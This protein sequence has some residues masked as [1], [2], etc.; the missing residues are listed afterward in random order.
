M[1]DT[2]RV[3][4]KICGMRQR[5]NI[6][7]VASLHPDYMGFIFYKGSK[8]FVGNDFG[9]PTLFP[10]SIKRIGVFVNAQRKKY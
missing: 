10:A 8:R 6:L 3:K 7:E 5:E 4:F 2:G 1:N 9:L